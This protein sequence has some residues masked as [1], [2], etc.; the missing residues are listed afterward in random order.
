MKIILV[1]DNADLAEISCLELR[2][3]HEHEVECAASGAKALRLAE[4]LI[5]DLMLIDIN[6]PD[7]DGYAL[8]QRLRAIPALDKTILVALTGWGNITEE[9][10]VHTAGFDTY[11]QKPMDFSIL[12][13]VPRLKGQD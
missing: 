12:P 9:S 13:T 11:F 10:R 2:D 6:L 5:P 4:R 3:V 8:A 1:E 7:M